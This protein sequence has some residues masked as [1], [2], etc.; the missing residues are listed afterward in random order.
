M[1]KEVNCCDCEFAISNASSDYSGYNL[2]HFWHYTNAASAI[3]EIAAG[4]N[5]ICMFV[6]G[7]YKKHTIQQFKGHFS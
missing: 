7:T 4:K 3:L 5:I 6:S 1:I 2:G